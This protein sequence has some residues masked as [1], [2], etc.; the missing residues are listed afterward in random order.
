MPEI[1]ARVNAM[2]GSYKEICK[3]IVRNIKIPVKNRMSV[4][5]IYLI[6]KGFFQACTWRR[7]KV[8]EAKKVHIGFM[9]ILRAVL[10]VDCPKCEHFTDDKVIETLEC[11]SPLSTVVY[12]RIDLRVR[13]VTKK[14]CALMSVLADAYEVDTS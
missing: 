14:H 2:K 4:I 3:E 8:A 12:L 13:M 7:L 9:T 5:V 11:L 1:V 6:T 10:R